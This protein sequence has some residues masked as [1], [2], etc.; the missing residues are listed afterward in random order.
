[1]S[2]DAYDLADR[3]EAVRG[4]VEILLSRVD[5]LKQFEKS[6]SG[7]TE[8][9]VRVEEGWFRLGDEVDQLNKK[10]CRRDW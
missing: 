4:S 7:C 2:N 5:G 3:I 1:M 6:C 8:S 10:I 9:W